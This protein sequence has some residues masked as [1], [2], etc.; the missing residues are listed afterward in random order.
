MTFF[1]YLALYV[2]VLSGAVLLGG[3]ETESFDLLEPYYVFLAIY[4][5]YSWGGAWNAAL[6]S[7]Q[8]DSIMPMYHWAVVLGLIGFVAG[9]QWRRRSAQAPLHLDISLS[10]FTTACWVMAVVFGILTFGHW[11][12]LFDL[13]A[14]LPYTET[15]WEWRLSRTASS[16]LVEYLDKIAITVMVAA[17]FLR[18]FTKKKV[19]I[20]SICLMI[21]YVILTIAEG[22]K[23]P[24][25]HAV[26][27]VVMLIHYLIRPIRV[28][29]ALVL[30]V[31]L[32]VFA[33]LFNNV[34]NTTQF[35]LMY[36]QAVELVREN[37]SVLLPANS[38]EL[39]GPSKTLMDVIYAIGHGNLSYSLGYTYVT[40]ALTVIP[41]ILYP[42]RPLPLS[43]LYMTIFYRQ[44]YAQGKGHGLFLLTEGY[45]A[46]GY[47][48]VLLEMFVYGWIVSRLYEAFL[49]NKH[50]G[51]IVLIYANLYL[52]M[53]L[54]ITRT[55]LLLS[56]KGTLMTFA[57]FAILLLLS[58]E[59][60]KMAATS[61]P[62]LASCGSP[63]ATLAERKL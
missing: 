38:G 35:S 20:I 52:P 22:S 43:E 60:R 10:K 55:G 59:P 1:V 33:T 57:P 41:R 12:R 29:H 48:G 62:K 56:L 51:P 61:L 28:R 11:S 15:A 40:E 49:P 3:R 63:R 17:L 30:G 34:R 27:L 2:S 44:E 25:V 14:M 26:L 31:G 21:A 36:S 5:L 9:Y 53:V 42:A 23:T 32:Y 37:P 6:Y 46:F 54:T 4:T 18:S 45:W 8:F 39:I 58:R 50:K 24:L 16:G 13:S 19:G 7:R 47:F